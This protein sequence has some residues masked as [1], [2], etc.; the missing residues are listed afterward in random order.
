MKTFLPKSLFTLFVLLFFSSS[1]SQSKSETEQ[2]ILEKMRNNIQE[3]SEHDGSV[4]DPVPS[5]SSR[6]H[7][8]QLRFDNDNLVIEFVLRIVTPRHNGYTYDYDA[9][10]NK[11]KVLI[12]IYDIKDIL[13]SG[14]KYVTLPTKSAICD[15]TKISTTSASIR[16]FKNEFEEFKRTSI[17]IN[18]LNENDENL[19]PRLNKAFLHLKQYY[20]K[21][22]KIQKKEIF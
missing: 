2:W 16:Y 5:S 1:Y 10:D 22:Q 17:T 19:V 9:K 15:E 12:P 4:F 21:P 13:K 20:P 3:L 6:S 18:L 11:V 8:Y 14:V 7:N